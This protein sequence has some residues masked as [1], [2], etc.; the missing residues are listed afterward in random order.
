MPLFLD[1]VIYETYTGNEFHFGKC[2]G[3]SLLITIPQDYGRAVTLKLPTGRTKSLLELPKILFAG[4]VP[5]WLELSRRET[6]W[7][8][9]LQLV[10]TIYFLIMLYLIRIEMS[11]DF[12]TNLFPRVEWLVTQKS[13][14]QANRGNDLYQIDFGGLFKAESDGLFVFARTLRG[15]YKPKIVG[16]TQTGAGNHN[17]HQRCAQEAIGK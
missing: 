3:W 13:F 4:V 10:V 2:G 7:C 6:G 8:C 12:S 11:D 1:F 17:Y 15:R 9:I 14:K 16:W 5:V